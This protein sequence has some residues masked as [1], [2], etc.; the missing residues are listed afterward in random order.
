MEI[1]A[2]LKALRLASHAV[3][4]AIDD[5]ARAETP[6]TFAAIVAAEHEYAQCLYPL[7]GITEAFAYEASLA[8]YVA[9]S[10]D[11]EA[12]ARRVFTHARTRASAALKRAVR[13]DI[14]RIR[15]GTDA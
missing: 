12:A 10:E 5:N 7:I 6:E 15:R 4:A 14:D 13:D 8:T 2:R 1:P 9:A 11:D 3:Q